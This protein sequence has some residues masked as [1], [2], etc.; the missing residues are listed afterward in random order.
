MSDFVVQIS[1]V[2]SLAVIIYIFARALPRLPDAAEKNGNVFDKVIGRLPLEKIDTTLSSFGER[3]LRKAKILVMKADH[4]IN[5]YINKIKA[6]EEAK[7]KRVD[8]KQKMAAL[9]GRKDE[10]SKTGE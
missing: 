4:L 10:T 8:L 3:F 1:L 5:G 9:N 7:Q 2:L 6:H